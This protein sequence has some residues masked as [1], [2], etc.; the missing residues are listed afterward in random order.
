MRYAS[1]IG[2]KLREEYANALSRGLRR[3]LRR[4]LDFITHS[5]NATRQAG[6]RALRAAVGRQSLPYLWSI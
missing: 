2:Q 1:S 5:G 6:R 3:V 4:H